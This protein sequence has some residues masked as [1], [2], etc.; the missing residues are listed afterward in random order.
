MLFVSVVD[1]NT[2]ADAARVNPGV[3]ALKPGGVLGLLG[4]SLAGNAGSSG[5][6][7]GRFGRDRGEGQLP[8]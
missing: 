4:F 3:L 7:H 6:I 5:R 8:L 2:S 1:T